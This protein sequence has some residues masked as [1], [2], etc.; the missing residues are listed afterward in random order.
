MSDEKDLLD[1]FNENE[2]GVDV[3]YEKA[4]HNVDEHLENA[5]YA[6]IEQLAEILG[7]IASVGEVE[8]HTFCDRYLDRDDV[9]LAGET[10]ESVATYICDTVFSVPGSDTVMPPA[11][12]DIAEDIARQCIQYLEEIEEG[13]TG[14]A[15]KREPDDEQLDFSITNTDAEIENLSS[16]EDA[17]RARIVKFGIISII[18][19]LLIVM[20]YF[21]FKP[22]W[23]T[24][25]ATSTVVNVSGIDMSTE[26]TPSASAPDRKPTAP[27]TDV[28]RTTESSFNDAPNA[29]TA[30]GVTILSPN[31]V[32][33]DS[34][35]PVQQLNLSENEQFNKLVA[36]VGSALKLFDSRISQNEKNHEQIVLA[37]EVVQESLNSMERG[38]F[39]G[40]DIAALNN[41]LS[42]LEKSIS[43]LNSDVPKT[44][45]SKPTV[46]V[47]APANYLNGRQIATLDYCI[48]GAVNG[49]AVFKSRREGK[50]IP[51]EVGDDLINYGKVIEIRADYTVITEHRGTQYIVKRQN[52]CTY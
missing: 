5:P 11:D 22:L 50:P 45:I 21:L 33:S 26:S 1:A 40:I 10:A 52:P 23:S 46:S 12:D 42:S 27:P 37:L 19:L 20:F 49:L 39:G 6:R 24:N 38:E 16:E 29:V 28:K 17:N 30:D 43:E 7:Q 48:T 9:D 4:S 31:G 18:A 35:F 34:G 32:T 25:N 13:G 41:R 36:E 51:V 47:S 15:V 44:T 8:I 2:A 3:E 14:S